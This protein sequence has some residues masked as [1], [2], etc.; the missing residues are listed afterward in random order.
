MNFG[1]SF[2]VLSELALDVILH[3]YPWNVNNFRNLTGNCPCYFAHVNEQDFEWTWLW[4]VKVIP[5]YCIAHPY[6][7]RFLRH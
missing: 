7:A 5:W 6:C 1:L 4:D 2:H 3:L